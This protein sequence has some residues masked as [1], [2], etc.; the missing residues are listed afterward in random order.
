MST[1]KSP[2]FLLRVSFANEEYNEALQATLEKA[3]LRQVSR[4]FPKHFDYN[5]N[6]FKTYVKVLSLNLNSLM[7]C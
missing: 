4:G 7:I 2:N 3:V 6:C 1:P 5:F